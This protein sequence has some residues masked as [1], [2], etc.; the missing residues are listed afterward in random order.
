MYELITLCLLMRGSTHGYV[1]AQTIN[2]VIGPIARASNG[3][4]Y[5]LLAQLEEDNYITQIEE[6]VSDGGRVSKIYSLTEAGRRRFHYLMMDTSSGP[7]EYRER[8]AF[9]V[10]AFDLINA[11]ERKQILDHYHAYCQQHISHIQN[12]L[13]AI[14]AGPTVEMPYPRVS[15]ILPHLMEMWQHEL[16]WATALARPS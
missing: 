1:I 12:Q 13:A 15:L 7:R 14:A 4:I 2:D 6:Q 11:S 9:K 5:P 10:T 3:R 8:F 16:A